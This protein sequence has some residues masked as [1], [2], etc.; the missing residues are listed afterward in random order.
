[1]KFFN[2]LCL[3]IGLSFSFHSSARDFSPSDICKSTI[4]VEMGRPVKTMK[5][6]KGGENP[7]VLYRRE[8]GDLFKYECIIN[9][10]TVVWRAY[11]YD[12]EKWGRWRNRYSEGDAKTSFQ[13]T[14]GILTITNNQVGEK[15]FKKTDF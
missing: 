5:I 6:S 13:N 15:S 3:L 2:I 11:F 8:D 1:M 12:E 14:N 9:A 10:N 7:I 4:S